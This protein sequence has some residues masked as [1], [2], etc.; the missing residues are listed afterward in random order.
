MCDL[1]T[2]YMTSRRKFV[3]QSNSQLFIQSTVKHKTVQQS[4]LLS[5]ND[6]YL[7]AWLMFCYCR[8]Y[9]LIL[10]NLGFKEHR[11]ENEAWGDIIYMIITL[12]ICK[13]FSLR[14]E[15]YKLH[16][17]RHERIQTGLLMVLVRLHRCREIS[18]HHSRH[19]PI[20]NTDNRR[21]VLF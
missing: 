11:V 18:D 6:L 20:L 15:S 1:I 7:G 19:T 10:I 17:S 9:H 21:V 2:T 4:E 12:L 13:I 14:Y 5:R 16:K 8:L 3:C